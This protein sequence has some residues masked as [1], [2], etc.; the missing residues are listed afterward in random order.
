MLAKSLAESLSMPPSN[1]PIF[2]AMLCP[3]FLDFLVLEEDFW[4]DF[5]LTTPLLLLPAEVPFVGRDDVIIPDT[6]CISC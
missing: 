3:P 4:S 2:R 6:R 1:L 5:F